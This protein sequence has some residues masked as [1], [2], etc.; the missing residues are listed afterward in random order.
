MKVLLL[1]LILVF[2][3]N[4]AQANLVDYVAQMNRMEVSNPH[5]H[6]NITNALGEVEIQERLDYLKHYANKYELEEYYLDFVAIVIK[7]T[8]FVNYKTLDD[9]LSFGWI[10]MRWS[11]AEELANKYHIDYTN[12]NDFYSNNIQA[13]LLVLYFKES[14]DRFGEINKSIVS[15]NVGRWAN[16][17]KYKYR[18]YFYEVKGITNYLGE[19]LD[20]DENHDIIISRGG[21]K[22]E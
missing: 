4:V 21:D 22:Y 7:E 11:T 10:S 9:G 18:S 5:N 6:L 16:F 19:I 17:R 1:I 14:L 20:N 15:Y 12:K 2:N 13:E 8:R 3:V